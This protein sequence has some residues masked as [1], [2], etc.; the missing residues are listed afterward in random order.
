MK[1]MLLVFAI[2]LLAAPVTGQEKS[3]EIKI[4]KK[5]IIQSRILD[6]ERPY[7]VYLPES[8]E[9]K[10]FAPKKY[11]VLYLLDGDAHFLAAAGVVHFMSAGINGN[12]QIPELII[13]AIPNTGRLRDMTPTNTI[14][15]FGGEIDSSLAASGGGDNFLRFLGDELIP[16]IDSSYRTLPFRVLTG[17]SLGGLIALHD[18]L[19]ESAAFNAYIAIDPSL[20]WDSQVLVERAKELLFRKKTTY[21]RVYLSLAHNLPSEDFDA[22]IHDNAVRAFGKL[23]DATRSDGQRSKLQYFEEEDHG[24]VPLLSLYNGLLFVFEGYKIS[25]SAIVEQPSAIT[26]HYRELSERLGLKLLPPEQ[27]INMAGFGELYMNKNTD[28]AIELF[29]VNVSVYPDSYNAYDCLAEAYMVKGEKKLAIENYKK[30]LELN[31]DNQKA[32][33]QLKKLIEK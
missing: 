26:T 8:Y 4:G 5:L 30:S 11:P 33:D 15:G 2:I 14:N 17:H 29:R 13:V 31:P 9:D 19:S 22:S 12:M 23:L 27:L 16:H 7:W 21:N 32:K 25:F 20:W 24:S 28:K 3:D 10:T 18:L 1:K 6:E